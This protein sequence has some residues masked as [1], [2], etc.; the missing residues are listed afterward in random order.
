MNMTTELARD[1]QLVAL[2]PMDLIPA[3]SQLIQWCLAKIRSL[4]MDLR[5]QRDNLRQAKTMKWKHSAW[6][7]AVRKTQARMVY[8]AKIK[9]AVT[10]GYL[11]VP[12]FD[13]DVVAVRVRR[14]DPC[15]C[16]DERHATAELLPPPAGR[17]VADKLLGVNEKRTLPDGKT[18]VTDFCCQE[19][20]SEIHFPVQLVKPVVLAAT[21]RAM[22]LRLFDRI[23][24]VRGG[25]KSDPIVV[26]QIIDPRTPTAYGQRQ[27]NPR[28]LSF[29]IAWWLDTRDL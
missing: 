27:N 6:A 1:T 11:I 14:S 3:Q 22:A 25:R 17:Y 9:S 5:E 2:T 28:C 26:G 8:Y 18:T 15:V 24:V 29:F 12:N 23:G 16:V 4:A 20:N 19:F 21:D 7:T 13:V 10:A